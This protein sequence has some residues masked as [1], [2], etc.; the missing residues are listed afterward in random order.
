MSTEI[1]AILNVLIREHAHQWQHCAHVLQ[2]KGETNSVSSP[3]A[4]VIQSFDLS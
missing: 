1:A 3:E 2:H 4:Y